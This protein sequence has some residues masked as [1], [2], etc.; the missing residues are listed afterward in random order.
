MKSGFTRRVLPCMALM[1]ALSFVSCKQEKVE[2]TP[3][4][5]EPETGG[6]YSLNDGEGGFRVGK[7]VAVEE[8]AIFIHLYAKRWTSRPT[9]SIAKTGDRPTGIAYS[10]QSFASM[11]PLRLDGSEVTAQELKDY[12]SWRRSDPRVF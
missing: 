1:W 11:Q 10:R 2:G 6:L 9:R 7:V 3:L 5:G 4:S 8:D 12:E